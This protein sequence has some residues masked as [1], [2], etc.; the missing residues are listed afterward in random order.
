MSMFNINSSSLIETGVISKDQNVSLVHRQAWMKSLER[1]GLVDA[2]R[3]I[4]V[5]TNSNS[6]SSPTLDSDRRGSNSSINEERLPLEESTP[7]SG[8]VEI[9]GKFQ[10]LATSR[11]PQTATLPSDTTS[12][13]LQGLIALTP[14]IEKERVYISKVQVSRVDS[15]AVAANKSH[16]SYLEKNVLMLNTN[17]GVEL[18]IR[19]MA[20]PKSKLMEMLKTVRHSMGVLGISL[21]KVVLNGQEVLSFQAKTNEKQTSL[22]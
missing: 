2:L 14:D 6:M 4:R 19:D 15:E 17:A 3:Q 16:M 10:S 18:W 9:V 20:L 1:A 8:L 7:S 11:S 12:E 22:V 5:M 13:V 21:V